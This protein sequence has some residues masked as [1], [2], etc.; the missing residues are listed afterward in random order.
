MKLRSDLKLFA[1]GLRGMVE[2]R[3]GRVPPR[4]NVSTCP[5]LVTQSTLGGWAIEPYMLNGLL[6]WQRVHKPG[7]TIKKTVILKATTWDGGRKV[8]S[9]SSRAFLQKAK[10]NV[11]VDNFKEIPRPLAIKLLGDIK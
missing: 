7:K 1:I 2:L 8:A 11:Q 10:L 9:F 5:R 6:E 3:V 4:L